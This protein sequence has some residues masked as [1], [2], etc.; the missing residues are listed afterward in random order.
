[1][2]TWTLDRGDTFLLSSHKPDTDY[3]DWI[4]E[5]GEHAACSTVPH[6]YRWCDVRPRLG[7]AMFLLC[8]VLV[9]S[10][11]RHHH[12]Y[13]HTAQWDFSR[14][15]GEML[16]S[17]PTFTHRIHFRWLWTGEVSKDFY[18]IVIEY[19]YK[20]QS[21][22]IISNCFR[23]IVLIIRKLK[24]SLGK[25]VWICAESVHKLSQM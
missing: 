17:T 16:Y 4:R 21:Y 20:K 10:V 8:L 13:G 19:K 22:Q 7:T 15:Q 11:I 25:G 14:S 2:G 9:P 6:H 12:Q 5:R 18:E 1:M 24:E 3:G 23:Y